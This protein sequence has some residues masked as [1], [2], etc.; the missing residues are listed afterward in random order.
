MGTDRH[1][2][3]LSPGSAISYWVGQPVLE[4]FG[5]DVLVGPAQLAVGERWVSSHGVGGIFTA[6]LLPVVRHLISIPAGILKM[7]FG[8]LS[9][10]TTLGAGLWCA[11]LSWF[12]V[13][14]L[15]DQPQLLDSPEQ[16]VAGIKARLSWFVAAVVV[17][18]V[19]YAFVSI[20]KGRKQWQA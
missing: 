2:K 4:R 20:W 13:K 7:P 19:A 5:K 9:A 16:M 14:V 3:C 18:A 15:G 6:R 8:R 10:V 11:V 12:G 17:L 1:L